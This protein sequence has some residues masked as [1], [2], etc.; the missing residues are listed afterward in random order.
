MFVA[1]R[2]FAPPRRE[3]FAPNCWALALAPQIYVS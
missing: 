2:P 1:A 3:I